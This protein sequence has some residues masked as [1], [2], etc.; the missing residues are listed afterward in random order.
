MTFVFVYWD[1]D[2]RENEVC[3]WE[4]KSERDKKVLAPENRNHKLISNM[5]HWFIIISIFHAWMR[6]LV[7][8]TVKY[9]QICRAMQQF[10]TDNSAQKHWSITFFAIYSC[11]DYNSYNI[12]NKL[13]MWKD[14]IKSTTNCAAHRFADP[15]YVL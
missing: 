11:P 13:K 2:E 3:E 1:V 9:W 7:S 15:F 6:A 4:R 12:P 8:R 10:C 14:H 5:C